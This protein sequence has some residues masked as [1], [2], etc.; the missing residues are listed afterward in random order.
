MSLSSL[1]HLRNSKTMIYVRI[2]NIEKPENKERITN[3]DVDMYK[4]L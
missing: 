4:T 2:I 3:D 1:P